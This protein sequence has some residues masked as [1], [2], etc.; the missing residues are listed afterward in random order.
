MRDATVR[1]DTTAT[2]APRALIVEQTTRLVELFR[3]SARANELDV[4]DIVDW[5]LATG[6]R[7]GEAVSLRT[8]E[9]AG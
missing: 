6:A 8:A 9:T 5:M 1:I 3:G 7:I 4:V 2:K